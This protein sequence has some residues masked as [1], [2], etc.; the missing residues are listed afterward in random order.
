MTVISPSASDLAEA[1]EVAFD[2]RRIRVLP[3]QSKFL[4]MDQISGLW[5]LCDREFEALL[6]QLPEQGSVAIREHAPHVDAFRRSLTHSGLGV[7]GREKQFSDLN[8]L[9][10][11]L[12]NACNLACTYCYD[13]EQ[14]ESATTL[15]PA[16]IKQ[17][18]SQALSLAPET[19]YIILHGGEPMLMW[20]LIEELVMFGNS[21]ARA[22]N[23][24][25]VF[26]G[27]SNFTRLTDRI[28]KFSSEHDIIWGISLDGD[29][30]LND[31]FRV[32]H[33]GGG[34]FQK[35]WRALERYPDFVRQCGV[36]STITAHNQAHLTQIARFF[37][38]IGMAAWDWS[39]FQP[40]GRGRKQQHFKPDM[41]A[42]IPAWNTLF[43]AVLD[44]E[45]DG[46]PI[47]PVQ[48]YLNNFVHGP[49][50]NM[51][52]RPRCGA[53]R[54]LLSISSDGAI[55]ACDC[56]DPDGPLS[57]LGHLDEHTLVDA[58]ASSV[59]VDIRSRDMLQHPRCS[60]CIWYGVCGGTC[61]A[62]ASAMDEIWEEGCAVALNAFDRISQ[63]VVDGDAIQRYM[64][65]IE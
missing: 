20:P 24:N 21:E 6:H 33:K 56:I 25:V 62:H 32:D 45:F 52:L 30:D 63:A 36:M 65:S 13:Y 8:T 23:K 43:D 2:A 10:L 11:K 22:Q 14:H 27:Q 50:G 37:R 40:I 4:I 55:E 1:E 15:S 46:F 12:T 60:A 18:I 26:T 49:A 61:L 19:L 44:G 48:K 59:A 9:I 34:S 64:K 17:A 35:F 42:L 7:P 51:C 31:R 41:N 16:H 47:M 53:A 3:R 28:V 54:D 38:H 5:G 58:R 29:P 57:P 39:L